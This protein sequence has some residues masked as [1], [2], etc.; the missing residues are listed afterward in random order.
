MFGLKGDGVYPPYRDI[1]SYYW[2]TPYIDAVTDNKVMI[3]FSSGKF[4]LH[5][6]A[7]RAQFAVVMVR[8]PAL[9][10]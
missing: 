2:A 6:S 5:N 8:A 10:N 9:M 7:N 3:G 4:G 1:N